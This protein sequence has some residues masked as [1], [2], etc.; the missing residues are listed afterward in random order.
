[1]PIRKGHDMANY[2]RKAILRTFQQMLAEKS[3][4]KITVSALVV[5]CEIS[6]NT[7]YYHFRDIYDLLDAW[8]ES[9]KTAILNDPNVDKSW[10]AVL[11][12]LMHRMQENP[13]IV[14]H[15]S[16]SISRER[17]EQCVFSSV[18]PQLY[19]FVCEQ[20]KG[21]NIPE[22]TLQMMTTFY[23]NSLLG[24]ILRF[25]WVDMK[26]DVD[27]SVGNLNRIFSGAMLAVVD[28]SIPEKR[29]S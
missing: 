23:C 8:L 4:E 20:A 19:T 22:E 2:T 25:L 12:A 11:R 5:R 3:F 17:L 24:F 28:P 27:T 18:E 10:D 26:M 21:Q 7:F 16:N 14:Y 29:H 13:K 15:L 9:Q 1:M 6:S